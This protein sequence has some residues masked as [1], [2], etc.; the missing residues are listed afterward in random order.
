MLV[1]MLG[2]KLYLLGIG[3]SVPLLE[4]FLNYE[5]AG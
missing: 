3:A 5:G 1:W 2:I 4:R